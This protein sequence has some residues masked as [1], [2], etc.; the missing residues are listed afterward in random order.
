[1]KHRVILAIFALTGIGLLVAYIVHNTEWNE[2]FVPTPLSGE[3]AKNPFYAAQKFAEA[4][5]ATTEWR[6]TL[7]TLPDD[8][9]LVLSN[10]HWDVLENRRESLE[11]WVDTGGRLVVDGTLIDGNY[12]FAS[13]SGIERQRSDEEDPGSSRA[14]IRGELCGTL[15]AANKD[16]T[17]LPDGESLDVCTLDDISFLYT[18]EPI[19]WG[20]VNEHGLQAARVEVGRGTVTVLNMTPFENRHLAKVDHGKL[21]VE[22]TDLRRGDRVIFVTE[23]E[24]ASILE[25]IWLYGAPVVVLAALSIAAFLW[26]GSVRFGP[27]IAPPDSARR[28]L[29]EQIRGTGQFT[30]RIGGGKALHAAAV[31]A[32]HETAHR[33]IARYT[34]LS[35]EQRIEAI[36]E[37]TSLNPRA[38]RNAL[39]SD[40]SR[41]RSELAHA[42]ALLE[43]ARRALRDT[44]PAAR[45][46]YE[47]SRSST[48]R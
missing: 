38:L 22:A 43:R 13:W 40:T 39:A 48:G 19:L 41:R 44:M 10:W 8:A 32:L 29:A 2:T 7:G 42:I 1:M 20:Y 23:Y 21:F 47:G 35:E 17:E 4:L 12:E 15:I 14:P 37:A 28:S 31:R 34:T 6:R 24:Q 33:R 18:D 27:L 46:L 16:G 26:R 3:A 5:G 45:T 11:R 36:A 30:L 25:L 9:V